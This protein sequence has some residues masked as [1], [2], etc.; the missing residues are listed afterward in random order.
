MKKLSVI[1]CVIFVLLSLTMCRQAEKPNLYEDV[2][3]NEYISPG[4]IKYIM[5]FE[6]KQS[7]FTLDLGEHLKDS[8]N[9]INIP[10]MVDK[11]YYDYYEIGDT[12]KDDFRMGS[13]IFKGSYGKWE[14]TV[15]DK[16]EIKAT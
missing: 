11:D 6:I 14:I 16:Q 13:F 3:N 4:E 15:K 1:V 7:H 5:T 2:F 9:K 10:I 8:A 12:I